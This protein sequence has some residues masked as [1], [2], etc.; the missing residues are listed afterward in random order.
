TNGKLYDRKAGSGN[1]QINTTTDWIRPVDFSPGAYEVKATRTGSNS[2]NGGSDTLGVWHVLSST[3]DL[4]WWLSTT[5]G[6]K[7]CTLTIDVRHT[8]GSILDTGVYSL[9]CDAT[10]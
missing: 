8:D 9:S 5:T 2:L 4:E 3:G 6:A 7:S 1:T 10:A